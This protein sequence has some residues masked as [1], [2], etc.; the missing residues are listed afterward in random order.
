MNDPIRLQRGGS[1]H[2]MPRSAGI[3]SPK[4]KP[5]THSIIVS[6]N[7]GIAPSTLG[8]RLLEIGSDNVEGRNQVHGSGLFSIE[9]CGR[10]SRKFKI[11]LTSRDA[12]GNIDKKTIKYKLSSFSRAKKKYE[13]EQLT[14]AVATC[15]QLKKN[16]LAASED[17]LDQLVEFSKSLRKDSDL[18]K[19]IQKIK[20]EVASAICN[21]A[22]LNPEQITEENLRVLSTIRLSSPQ[23]SDLYKK[24]QEV[25]SDVDAA[26][27]HI[28]V[29][30][31][32][33]KEF[34][35]KLP[36]DLKNTTLDQTLSSLKSKYDHYRAPSH[37]PGFSSQKYDD[38]KNAALKNAARGYLETK[39][40]QVAEQ[41][42][43]KNCGLTSEV[44]FLANDIR[45]T[46]RNTQYLSA[47]EIRGIAPNQQGIFQSC[48]EQEILK[49]LSQ[50]N[51][52]LDQ[53]YRDHGD[54]LKTWTKAFVDVG[55]LPEGTTL[56]SL[57][58][59]VDNGREEVDNTLP[60]DCVVDLND[61]TQ[62]EE[63]YIPPDYDD[64][65]AI[66]A[67]QND[68]TYDW[69]EH[70]ADPDGY[71]LPPTQYKANPDADTPPEE[72]GKQRS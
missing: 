41:V 35:E 39:I 6:T 23:N 55:L 57:V 2:S 26:Q 45:N 15:D 20:Q 59:K 62:S 19:E 21:K 7:S 52:D 40:Q 63:E 5:R 67:Y 60:D 33:Q 42:R 1:M 10:G 64:L 44:F 38:L 69:F 16:P 34:L 3:G 50:C 12:N 48:F 37:I 49:N 65:N 54:Q 53:F 58:E 56:E 17:A 18:F 24:I 32:T 22:R 9:P 13:R 66:T 46:V 51:F 28:R 30:E 25:E 47:E 14:H 31:G 36:K 43:A 72:L 61:F 27:V 4:G 70:T 29:I 68:E 11:T 8:G 71:D